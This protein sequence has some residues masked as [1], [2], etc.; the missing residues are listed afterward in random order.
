MYNSAR[1]CVW[2]V[3]TKKRILVLDDDP[4]IQTIAA[5]FV[6]SVGCACH[7]VSSGEEAV[8]AYQI[9]IEE[10]RP[11]LLVLLDLNIDQGMGGVETVAA[12]QRVDPE[13]TAILSSG[14]SADPAMC[15]FREYGFTTTLAKPFE[16]EKFRNLVVEQ[17][18]NA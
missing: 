4:Q 11:Y 16:L 1:E 10:G 18:Q 6:E 7:C 9:A 14:D 8:A 17:T 13:V 12:L 5:L 15:N 3:E 2:S